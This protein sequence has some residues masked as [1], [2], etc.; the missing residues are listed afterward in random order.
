VNKPDDDLDIIEH[1]TTGGDL[2]RMPHP[3]EGH[4]RPEVEMYALLDEVKRAEPEGVPTR[5]DQNNSPDVA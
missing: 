4:G 3:D 2:R 5:D 1:L